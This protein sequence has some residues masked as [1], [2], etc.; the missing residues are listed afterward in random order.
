MEFLGR[1]LTFDSQA[2]QDACMLDSARKL[3]SVESPTLKGYEVFR[4][5]LVTVL[6]RFGEL[7][8]QDLVNCSCKIL[9]NCSCESFVNR[10]CKF[11]VNCS[12]KIL[13]LLLGSSKC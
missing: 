6:A 9:V 1:L 11:F 3:V 5:I 12:C 8:L 2:L 10:S 7:F 13:R 4:R